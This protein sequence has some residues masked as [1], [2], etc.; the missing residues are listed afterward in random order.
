MLGLIVIFSFFFSAK[1]I[2]EAL[3]FWIGENV[4]SLWKYIIF[5][6]LEFRVLHFVLRKSFTSSY[7]HGQEGSTYYFSNYI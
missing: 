7:I 4:R 5:F 1:S 6:I 2:Q 3:N